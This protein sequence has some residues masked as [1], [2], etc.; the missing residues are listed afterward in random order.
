MC[1]QSYPHAFF[2]NTFHRAPCD[3]SLTT[4]RDH[5]YEAPRPGLEVGGRG[6]RAML[7]PSPLREPRTAGRWEPRVAHFRVSPTASHL[8]FVCTAPRIAALRRL[9][10]LG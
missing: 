6:G 9:S 7:P 4:S 1:W 8:C 3:H 2:P 10:I 5:R